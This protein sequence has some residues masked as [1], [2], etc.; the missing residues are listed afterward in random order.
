MEH[1]DPAS[2]VCSTAHSVCCASDPL[3]FR[4][5]AQAIGLEADELRRMGVLC[6]SD[7]VLDRLVADH[8]PRL[9]SGW[10]VVDLG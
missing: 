7:E 9:R 8:R 2:L 3:T 4:R 5:R 6:G 10:R 1:R